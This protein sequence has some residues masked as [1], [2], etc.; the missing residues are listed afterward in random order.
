MYSTHKATGNVW[1]GRIALGTNIQLSAFTQHLCLCRERR[2][3]VRMNRK[4][5]FERH[6]SM[7]FSY[8]TLPW[9]DLRTAE[10]SDLSFFRYLVFRD[11]VQKA[12]IASLT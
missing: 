5:A 4:A 11:D 2:I 9:T 10:D 6:P 1:C 8:S 12:C 3:C 7:L